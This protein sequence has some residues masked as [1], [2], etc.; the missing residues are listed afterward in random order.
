MEPYWVSFHTSINNKS[1][2][3]K[4][5]IPLHK[6]ARLSYVKVKVEDPSVYIDSWNVYKLSNTDFNT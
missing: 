5:P 4:T 3:D 1:V 2:K 6:A